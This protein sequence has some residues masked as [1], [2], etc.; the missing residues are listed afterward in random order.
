MGPCA[1]QD[2]PATSAKAAASALA[3]NK[4]RPSAAEN[5]GGSA[6]GALEPAAWSALR[7]TYA[8]HRGASVAVASASFSSEYRAASASAAALEDAR[9]P[10]CSLKSFAGRSEK[11]HAG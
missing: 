7:G 10:S 2:V 1:R 11:S 5:P 9:L 8:S 4:F 6:S 3:R